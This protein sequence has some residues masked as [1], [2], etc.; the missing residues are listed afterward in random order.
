MSIHYD[1]IFYN[2]DENSNNQNINSNNNSNKN[3]N[4]KERMSPTALAY[5]TRLKQHVPNIDIY[6][7]GSITNFTFFENSSDVDCCI[8]YPDEH[9]KDKAVQFI[10]ED[11]L[12]FDIKRI[13]FQQVK[14]SH[15]KHPDEFG[16]VYCIFFD[17]G[18]KIDFNLVSDKI[19]PILSLQHNTNVIFLVILY[20]LK[21]LYYYAHLV[22]KD[23]FIYIKAKMFKIYHYI[24]DISVFRSEKQVIKNVS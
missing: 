14:L 19:G 8:V 22:S 4:I 3:N 10:T 7:F 2:E 20:I 15:P 24:H 21:W 9:T 16:D 13:T 1:S 12:Q 17:D 5:I 6:F 23:A 18:N 11:S